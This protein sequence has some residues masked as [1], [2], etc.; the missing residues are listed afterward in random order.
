MWKKIPVNLDL[1]FTADQGTTKQTRGPTTSTTN[2]TKRGTNL[3]PRNYV[4]IRASRHFNFLFF[5]NHPR[6]IHR[7]RF[8]HHICIVA[9]TIK[10]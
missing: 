7:S 5:F 8:Y 4:D 10:R 2:T 6:S 1:G 9:N 3:S